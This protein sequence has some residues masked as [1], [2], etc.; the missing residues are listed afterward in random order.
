MTTNVPMPFRLQLGTPESPNPRGQAVRKLR[1]FLAGMHLADEIGG[2]CSNSLVF[3]AA[4]PD[5][6]EVRFPDQSSATMALMA[7]PP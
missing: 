4:D 6:V 2:W 3:N 1:E 5:E 7:W